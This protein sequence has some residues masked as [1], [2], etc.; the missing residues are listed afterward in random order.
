MRIKGY[1]AGT[2]IV[3]CAMAF[4][5]CA[6]LPMPQT[7]GVDQNFTKPIHKIYIVA[8]VPRS[9]ATDWLYLPGET[10]L[11][12]RTDPVRRDKIAA[13]YAA[14]MKSEFKQ[15]GVEAECVVPGIGIVNNKDLVG[16][17]ADSSP[18]AVLTI[19]CTQVFIRSISSS[20][21]YSRS[22][23]MSAV[24]YEVALTDYPSGKEI[25]TGSFTLSVYSLIYANDAARNV[26]T[27]ILKGLNENK[28]YFFGTAREKK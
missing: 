2:F 1:V 6:S 4:I 25:W 7:S 18:D 8:D 26:F 10:A 23:D 24:S 19:T 11:V 13:L 16:K 15:A 28:M 20:N 12:S 3:F 17:A 9:M 27:T 5:G 21:S 14:V 22:V